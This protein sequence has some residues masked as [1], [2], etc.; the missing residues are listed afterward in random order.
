MVQTMNIFVA[1]LVA[2]LGSVGFTVALR[3]VPPFS[4]W[5]E[6]GVKPWACDLCM[7]FWCTLWFCSAQTVN[8]S[9][10]EAAFAWMPAF[11]LAYGIVQ[12]IVPTPMGEPPIDPQ[13]PDGSP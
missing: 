8:V 6:N 9:Y 12:R 13:S 7:S 1:I 10:A 4:T 3:A 11:A 2:A 5:N